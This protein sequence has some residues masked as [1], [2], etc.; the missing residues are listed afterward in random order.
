MYTLQGGQDYTDVLNAIS[1]GISDPSLADTLR[2]GVHVRSLGP[3]GEYSDGFTIVPAPGAVALGSVGLL[4][5]G[6]LRKRK[7]L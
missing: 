5:V 6:W 4:L 2:V 7:T 3:G 1:L